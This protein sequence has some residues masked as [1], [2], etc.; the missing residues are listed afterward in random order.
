MKKIIVI[1]LALTT[2]LAMLAGCVGK[3]TDEEPAVDANKNGLSD[4]TE[5][6][7]LDYYVELMLSKNP[8]ATKED[9]NGIK[10]TGYFGTYNGAVVVFVGDGAWEA[11]STETV[12]D[13][14]FTYRS[15][16]YLQV[17][18]KNKLYKLTEAYN[19]GIITKG[20]LEALKTEYDAQIWPQDEK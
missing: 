18:H 13:I 20:N 1:F 6:D 4:L 3:K 9:Y 15:S 19:E 11:Y 14:E 5:E 12:A 8:N 10:I 2:V 16:N 7:I 17:W